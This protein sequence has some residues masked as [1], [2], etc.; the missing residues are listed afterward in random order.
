MS[1]PSRL[2]TVIASLFVLFCFTNAQRPTLV[3]DAFTDSGLLTTGPGSSGNQASQL[4]LEHCVG[5]SRQ[6]TNFP[7]GEIDSTIT[8]EVGGRYWQLI[9]PEGNSADFGITYPDLNGLDLTHGAADGITLSAASVILGSVPSFIEVTVGQ[10]STTFAVPSDGKDHMFTLAF[11]AG[12][13]GEDCTPSQFSRVDS[14]EISARVTGGWLSISDFY[15]YR[16]G[17]GETTI[18]TSST[19]VSMIDDFSVEGDGPKV[20]VVA[21]PEGAS[22]NVIRTIQQ[23]NTNAIGSERD[24]VMWVQSAVENALFRAVVEDN[25]MVTEIQPGCNVMVSLQYDGV[26]HSSGVARSNLNLNLMGEASAFEFISAQSQTILV[27]ITTFSADDRTQCTALH[28]LP[29]SEVPVVTQV[30]FGEFSHGCD[31]YNIGAIQFTFQAPAL[32]NPLRISLHEL[33]LVQ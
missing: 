5:G 27:Q 21:L 14:I 32:R 18:T 26:D 7:Q 10:C 30:G 8:S 28:I 6:F 13:W 16:T 23:E 33:Y 4:D 1:S 3:I 11:V 24:I 25:T 9:V 2:T 22:S 20:L 29:A 19:V 17:S 31:F 15:V 12:A